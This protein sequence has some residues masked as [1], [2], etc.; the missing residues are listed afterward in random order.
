MAKRDKPKRGDGIFMRHGN[1]YI[2]WVNA[3]GKRLKRR[4]NAETLQQARED[5]A[6]ELRKV[7]QAK[8]YGITPPTDKS[9]AVVAAEYLTEQ[10]RKLS[11]SGHLRE[12]DII[13]LQLK[14]AFPVDIA[15]IRPLHIK[16]YIT[17]RESDV[18]PATVCKELNVL[19]GI[20]SF[21]VVNEYLPTSPAAEIS[22][23]RVPRSKQTWLPLN[24]FNMVCDACPVWLRPMAGFAFYTGVRLGN[25]ISMDWSYV[26]LKNRMLMLPT[27]KNGEPLNVPLNDG[28]MLVLLALAA[29]KIGKGKV[30]NYSGPHN[31][32]SVEFK[33]AARRVGINAHFHTLRHS[34]CA[35]S[36]MSGMDAITVQKM[37]GHK[38]ASMTSRYAHLSPNF[39]KQETAKMDSYFSA[40]SAGT[41]TGTFAPHMLLQAATT[42]NT[43]DT[44]SKQDRG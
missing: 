7:N 10:K 32:A 43:A 1:F 39:L 38:T 41:Q 30:F 14:P 37:M 23:P 40:L 44:E 15:D 26:N 6:E 11:D 4:A 19:K 8:I 20:F 2:S 9:F 28:A 29:G 16:S 5:R 12:S 3:S 13:R 35:H 24:E 17:K 18:S 21:C 34:F 42:C 25:I 27:T 33:R 22:G 31:R 36:I